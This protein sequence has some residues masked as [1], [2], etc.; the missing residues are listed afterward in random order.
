MLYLLDRIRDFYD[1]DD[2]GYEEIQ[3]AEKAA[4]A[5]AGQ[6]GAAIGGQT[7]KGTQ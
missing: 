5:S 6:A 4:G 1:P 2:E 3:E 7:R